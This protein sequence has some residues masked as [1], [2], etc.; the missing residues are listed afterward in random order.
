MKTDDWPAGSFPPPEARR[1]PSAQIHISTNSPSPTTGIY[2][3][4][5][6]IMRP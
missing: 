1:F 4:N 3:K 5:Y 6:R 2:R